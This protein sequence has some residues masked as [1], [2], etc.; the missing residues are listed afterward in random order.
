M[1]WALAADAVLAFHF[2]FILW[3]VFG[4][5]AAL[6][7]RRAIWLH[8]PALAWG[9][10]I[11]FLRPTCPLTPLE[12]RLRVL[13]GGQAYEGTFIS[14]YLLPIVYPG[15]MTREVQWVL[16]ALLIGFNLAVYA[17]LWRRRRLL[18]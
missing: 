11:E 4:G 8:L 15:A 14:H 7:W 3:V 6:R 17:L 2:A 13:A 16:G 9:I 18:R 1:A 12:N 10:A 5:L